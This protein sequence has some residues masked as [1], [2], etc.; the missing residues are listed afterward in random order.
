M[1]TDAQTG[2]LEGLVGRL[3]DHESGRLTLT[4][5]LDLTPDGSGQPPVLQP[6]RH[7]AREAGAGLESRE[8]GALDEDITALLAAAEDASARGVLGLVWVSHPVVEGH[9]DPAPFTI[10]ELAQPI[11]SSVSV[12]DGP[13]VFEVARAAYLDRPVA[14]VTTDMHTMDVV[15]VRYGAATGSDEVDWPQHYTSKLGQRT[16]RS[17]QGGPV[18]GTAG[19]GHAYAN[20]ER[21]VEAQR[22]LFANEAEEH[23]AKFVH[24]DDLLVVEG[25]DEARSQLLARLPESV[26]ARAVQLNAPPHGEEE[27]ERYERLRHLALDVQLENGRRRTEQW[28]GGAEPNAVNGLEAIGHA[29]EQGRVATVI[30]H[31]DAVDHLGTV[32][33]TRLHESSIDGDAVERLLQAALRQGALAVFADDERLLGEGGIVAIGR[34]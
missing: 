18:G 22:N 6:F 27:R 14:L 7:A 11:R 34:Y 25:V 23:V 12:G 29:C 8:A 5:T 31:Q 21:W 19:T 26:A 15:R 16:N 1:T 10:L 33:D 3:L 30:V 4:A 9:A 2:R 20:V 32:E 13:R 24:P 17:A 28:F